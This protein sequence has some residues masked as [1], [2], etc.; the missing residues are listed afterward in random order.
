MLEGGVH[1]RDP[2]GKGPAAWDG[3]YWIRQEGSRDF[4]ASRW[5]SSRYGNRRSRQWMRLVWLAIDGGFT[6]ARKVVAPVP[7]PPLTVT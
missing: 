3:I 7:A 1:G 4:F 6:L 2:F 5:P